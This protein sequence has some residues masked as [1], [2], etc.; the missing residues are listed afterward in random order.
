MRQEGAML[1]VI[2]DQLA[3]VNVL[4][5]LPS[6]IAVWVPLPFDEILQ[7]VF[8]A[9][10]TVIDDCFHFVFVLASDQVGWRSDEVGAV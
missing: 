3:H 10:E 7:V 8:S 4:F 6:V 2:S 1:M 5:R 9:L